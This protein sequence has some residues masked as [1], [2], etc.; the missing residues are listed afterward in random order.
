MF[1]SLES[2]FEPAWLTD[3]NPEQRAAA[4]HEG[5]HLLILAGAG[6]GKTTTLCARVGRL[7]LNQ[8]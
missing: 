7:I 6:T 4:E 5:G 1:V 8:A 3:L 2:P